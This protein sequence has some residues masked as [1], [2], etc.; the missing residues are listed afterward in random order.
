MKKNI[1]CLLAPLFGLLQ[2]ESSHA[3]QPPVTFPS[4]ANVCDNAPWQLVFFDDFTG[5]TI[6]PSKWYTFNTTNG[7][8]TDDWGDGRVPYPGNHSV[9]RD[10]NVTVSGGT[11]K[12]KIKQQTNTW[13]CA[14]CSMTPYTENYTSGYISSNTTYNNGKIEAR[15]KMPIFNGAWTTCWTWPTA[16][17]GIDEIDFAESKAEHGAPSWPYLG[18]R[19]NN[20]HS[21]HAWLPN[22]S[23]DQ[24]IALDY[25]N[26]SWLKWITNAS[27]RHHF[28]DWHTYTT[29]WDDNVISTYLDGSVVS[30]IWKYYY[31]QIVSFQSGWWTFNYTVKVPS[32]CAPNPGTTYYVTEGFP[33]N[34]SS[35]SKLIFSTAM[36]N[37][38]KIQSTD[39]DIGQ[40]EIDYV[41]VFQRHPEL[42]HHTQICNNI[43]PTITGPGTM[44]GRASYTTSPTTSGGTWSVNNDGVS[45]VGSNTGS[46]VS[47]MN[48]PASANTTS[49][50][51]YTYSPSG[52]PPV[53][54]SKTVNS[55]TVAA[56]VAVFLNQMAWGTKNYVLMASSA[57]TGNTYQWKV[58]YGS[59]STQLGPEHDYTGSTISTA[60]FANQDSYYIKWE[61]TVTNSCG[62][63]TFKGSKNYS[64]AAG[65][66]PLLSK[67]S[68]FMEPDTS[69]LYF[70]ANFSEP[71]STEYETTVANIV[72]TKFVD[73]P[74]DKDAI[75]EMIWKVRIDALEPY[76]YFAD[77]T[78][79]KPSMRPVTTSTGNLTGNESIIYPNPASQVLKVFPSNSYSRN[80]KIIYTIYNTIGQKLQS[81]YL[82]DAIDISK[83]PSGNYMIDLVQNGYWE[84]LKFIKS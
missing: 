66:Y 70:E 3:Q 52:C 62:S 60:S 75:N 40:M 84:H 38:Q 28:D 12:L 30:T 26:Q 69:A 13:Q 18:S 61:L 78:T 29:E 77:D 4:G 81:G 9:I 57:S 27:D 49:I 45:I 73:D 25:P 59:S 56:F 47:V 76:L 39:G 64:A 37:S 20:S 14:T 82:N 44:C 50:L 42:D 32:Y 33:Y 17:N 65:Y 80:D 48:N 11:V 58:W 34:T 74:N 79:R 72:G 35:H 41:K 2:V 1:W 63:K 46:S 19:P 67:P 54:I 51:S 22:L 16:A 36:L 21:L 71:D 55:G 68:S 10:Q 5:G 53:T 24:R 15:L 31:N 23:S 6:D 8:S 43:L 7:G 83:L